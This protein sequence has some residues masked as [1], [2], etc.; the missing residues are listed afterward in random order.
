MRSALQW[1]GPLPK[2]LADMKEKR[3]RSWNQTAAALH[4]FQLESVI[5][6]RWGKGH[7]IKHED[8]LLLLDRV[9]GL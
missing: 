9:Q 6:L 1:V 7:Q 2:Y 8:G 4:L 3:N 5:A